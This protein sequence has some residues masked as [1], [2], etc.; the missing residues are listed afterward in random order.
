[1]IDKE[2]VAPILYHPDFTEEFSIE[3]AASQVGLGAVLTHNY[4][5][6]GGQISRPVCSGQVRTGEERQNNA[7]EHKAPAVI[8]AVSTLY[9]NIMGMHFTIITNHNALK[10]LRNKSVQGRSIGGID[11][12]P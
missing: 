3:A 9:L 6:E 2:S 7:T 1:M 10:A 12:F 8:W 11:G 5:I 4:K